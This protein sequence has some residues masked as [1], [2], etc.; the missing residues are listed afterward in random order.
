MVPIHDFYNGFVKEVINSKI[1]ADTSD[2]FSRVFMHKPLA[3]IPTLL[4]LVHS[5]E[6]VDEIAKTM[7]KALRLRSTHSPSSS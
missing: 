2:D 7:A 4:M 1:K 6:V 5:L 3:L